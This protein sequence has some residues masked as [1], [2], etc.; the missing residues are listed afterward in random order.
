MRQKFEFKLLDATVAGVKQHIETVLD[1]QIAEAEE[2]LSLLKLAR[3]T[4]ARTFGLDR[5]DGSYIEQLVDGAKRS[6]T[7]L[8]EEALERELSLPDA[9]DGKILVVDHLRRPPQIT[10]APPP[11]PARVKP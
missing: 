1:P 11:G 8:D 6:E 3:G 10:T 5:R 9:E 7:E 2:N 4:L